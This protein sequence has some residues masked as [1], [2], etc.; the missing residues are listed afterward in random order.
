MDATLIPIW[1][2]EVFG[3]HWYPIQH[4]TA[5]FLPIGS[6]G[7]KW[8]YCQNQVWKIKVRRTRK[9][10]MIMKYRPGQSNWEYTMWKF[11]EF[12]ATQ[13]FIRNRFGYFE[14]PK[15]A[16]LPTW[17]TLNFEFLDIC[18]IFKCEI[19]KKTRLKSKSFRL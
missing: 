17:A 6:I 8:P 5:N 12:S 2:L 7:Y 3:I 13:I 18:D 19:R 15:T 11:Q 10:N 16:I 14:A 4:L 1:S 9:C